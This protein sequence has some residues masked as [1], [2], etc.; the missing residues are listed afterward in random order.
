[1]QG[2]YSAA[3]TGRLH[4]TTSK[5][6]AFLLRFSTQA[7]PFGMPSGPGLYAFALSGRETSEF[8]NY[9]NYNDSSFGGSLFNMMYPAFTHTT[10]IHR[11]RGRPRPATL[12]DVG[13]ACVT[14][15]SKKGRTS[16]T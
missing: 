9:F 2:L 1:M 7:S 4:T 16:E 6:R 12:G 15:W 3:P 14:T 10:S 13:D 11:G 8:S 5:P